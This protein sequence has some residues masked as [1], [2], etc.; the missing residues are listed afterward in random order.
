MKTTS[1]RWISAILVT[2]LSLLP[3]ACAK[4]LLDQPAARAESKEV[5]ADFTTSR[6]GPTIEA[7]Q[8]WDQFFA[9]PNLRELIHTALSNNQELNIALQ[10]IIVAKNE[11]AGLK[12]EYLPRL[13]ATAGAGIEKVGGHSSQGVSDEAHG[14]AANLPDFRFG[15]SASWEI[16]AW[17]KLRGAAKAA[18][19]RYAATVEGKNFIITEIIAE[20]AMSYYELV[21][22]DEQIEVLSRNIELQERALEVV[23]LEKK[24]GRAT[25]LAVRKFQAEVLKNQG[26]TFELEQRRVEV[27]NRINVL[28]GR[29]PQPVKRD[30]RMF[31]QEL[32]QSVQAG[33][34][35][36]LLDNRPDVR[37]AQFALEASKLD[38]K[39]A[40]TRFYPS[41]SIEADVGYQAFNA[42]HLLDTPESM[43]YNLAGNIVAPLLNRKAIKAEYRMA[44]AMQIQAV[45]HFE[46]TVLVA[47]TEV[48]TQLALVQNE[49]KR[50]EQLEKQVAALE[51]AT[52]V[53][54]ILY[55]SARADYM[56]VLMT[57]RDALEAEME[58]ID[59]RKARLQAMVGIYQALGGGWHEE[60]EKAAEKAA[61]ASA[62]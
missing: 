28:V 52:E 38:V 55:R 26:R 4:R 22:L 44:N 1:T 23:K 25:E 21:A 40:K 57:R 30:D 12:G 6:G 37:Q 50:F 7:Q 54:S 8:H 20:I 34:P 3:T 51:D 11:A 47:F 61:P 53:S 13:D 14:V 39:V 24:A 45:L 41:F 58:L 18:G 49:S 33:L 5:P 32:P 16:D 27:E 9:D 29:F 35:S 15:L 10:E 36:D 59:A 62:G 17:G 60:A 31:E 48:A 2:S 42:R 46:K 56:E 43:V 19:M